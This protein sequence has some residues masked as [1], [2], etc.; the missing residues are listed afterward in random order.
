MLVN[1][2]ELILRQLERLAVP[3]VAFI[4]EGDNCVDPIVAAVELDHNE[5][6]A[7]ALG[8]GRS[9]SACKEA[10]DGRGQGDQGR[11]T[12]TELEEVASRGHEV[13]FF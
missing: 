3:S 6:A 13:S 4:G 12:Q 8:R 5:H 9:R 7:V 2:D 1:L 10:G 11:S